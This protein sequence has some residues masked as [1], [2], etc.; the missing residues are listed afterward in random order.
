MRLILL[1]SLL[2]LLAG[3][4]PPTQSQLRTDMDLEAMKRRL[5]Q[6]EIQQAETKISGT[7]SGDTQTRQVAEL[8]AGQ[9]NMRVE[10]QSI[11]GRMDDM[12][13]NNRQR[14]DEV[15]LIK[16]D[17]GL[18]LGSL[19]ERLDQLEQRTGELGKTAAS[20]ALATPPPETAKQPQTPEQIYQQALDLI[21]KENRFA[22]GRELLD[23]FVKTYPNHD[24]T[25]NALYWSGEALY[26]EKKYELAILQL[27]DVISKYPSHPKAAAA[28][29]KQALA[30]N[31]LGDRQNARTTMQKLIEEY[32]AAEQIDSAKRF[33]AE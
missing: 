28:M 23:Q 7:S 25:V 13:Q 31:A 2:L 1:F 9:D 29:F 16:D 14:A 26:G 21:R 6:L 4:L 5:A 18:Q 27:Q 30:F 17:L 20:T 8:L 33:L 10:L 32:P 3:C 19:L 12:E 24:L 22:K 15:Q 11:N